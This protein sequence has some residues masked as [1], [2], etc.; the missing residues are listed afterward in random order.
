MDKNEIQFFK[1]Q[2]KDDLLSYSVYCDR[3]FEIAPHHILIADHLDKLL[4]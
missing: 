2:A 1:E 4:K 3:F